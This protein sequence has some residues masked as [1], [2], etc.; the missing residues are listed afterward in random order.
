MFYRKLILAGLL[1]LAT[2]GTGFGAGFA[3]I[4]QSVS[5]LGNAYAGGAAIADDAST[6][7]FNPAGMTRLKGVQGVAGMH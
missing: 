3:L 7:Y 2:A 6:V 1:L 5:G 4:E